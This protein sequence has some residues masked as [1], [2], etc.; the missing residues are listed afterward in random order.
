MN[1]WISNYLWYRAARNPE[2]NRTDTY[3]AHNVVTTWILPYVGHVTTTHDIQKDYVKYMRTEYTPN[4]FERKVSNNYSER[5][6][7]QMAL[8]FWTGWKY[9]HAPN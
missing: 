2:E 1:E 3:V 4:H 7:K 8:Q 9:Y 6:L 5:I